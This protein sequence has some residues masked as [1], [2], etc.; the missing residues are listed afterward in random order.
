M[1]AEITYKH[2]LGEKIPC[3]YMLVDSFVHTCS[4][5][6]FIYL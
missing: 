1:T 5:Y 4:T 3:M 6:L 2:Q